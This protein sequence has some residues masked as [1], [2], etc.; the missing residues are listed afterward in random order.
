MDAAT[1][2]R[3]F[4]PFFTTKK[5][6]EGTGL[7]LATVYGVVKQSGGDISVRTAPGEG[8]TFTLYLPTS[9]QPAVGGK[10]REAPPAAP[11]TAAQETVLVVEDDDAVRVLVRLVLTRQ[12]YQVLEAPDGESAMSLVQTYDEPIHLLVSDVVMPGVSGPDLATKMTAQRPDLRVLFLSGYTEDEVF[13]RGGGT[14]AFL[15]KPFL[16]TVLTAK[17]R[18]VLNGQIHSLNQ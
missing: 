14:T 16:P 15:H 2:A 13:R 9:N 18:E 4:E 17:V 1:K 5:V 6:G 3:L 11:T 10:Q 7:G 8:T 12:G